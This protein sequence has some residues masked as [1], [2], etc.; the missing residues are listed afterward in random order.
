MTVYRAGGGWGWGGWRMTFHMLN[1]PWNVHL[2]IPRN[3]PGLFVL[4]QRFTSPTSPHI[5]HY[6]ITA[7]GWQ[8]AWTTS[9][10]RPLTRARF[11]LWVRV[12]VGVL[13]NPQSSLTPHVQQKYW[14]FVAPFLYFLAPLFFCPL[15]FRRKPNGIVRTFAPWEEKRMIDVIFQETSSKKNTWSESVT[16]FPAAPCYF[17]FYFFKKS[18]T[19]FKK[20]AGVRLKFEGNKVSVHQLSRSNLTAAVLPQP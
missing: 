14:A 4:Q 1:Q 12:C 6:L 5:N 19:G 8:G 3:S 13:S 11:S 20:A 16:V 2:I 10:S 18:W 9:V 7:R 17:Y 15:R